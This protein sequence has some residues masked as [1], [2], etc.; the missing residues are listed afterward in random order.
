M[1]HGGRWLADY[2]DAIAARLPH[3]RASRAVSTVLHE[4]DGVSV[5]DSTGGWAYYDSIVVATHADQALAMLADASPSEKEILGAFR[6]S[7][8]ETVLHT[9]SALLPSTLDGPGRRGTTS[10]RPQATSTVRRWSRIG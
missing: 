2:V 6:Y 9:D 10:P 4:G 5:Q 8:S 3:V 1:V 7:R